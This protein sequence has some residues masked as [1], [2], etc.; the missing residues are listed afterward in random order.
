MDGFEAGGAALEGEGRCAAEPLVRGGE[1]R[2]VAVERAAGTA[3]EPGTG[4]VER[5]PE[6]CEVGHDEPSGGRRGRGADVRG[7]VEE[8]GVLLVPDGAH[9]RHRAGGDRPHEPLVGEGK[10]VLEAAPATGDHDDVGAAGGEVGDG[11]SDRRRR[12]RPLHERLGDDDVRRRKPRG[13]RGQDVPLRG[14]V[15]PGDEADQLRDPGK[16]PLPLGC[17]EPLGGQ[18]LL[19][20][21]EGGEMRAEPVPLDRQRPEV[22]V[23]ALLVQL[24]TTVDVN[25]LA[26]LEAEPQ[27]VEEPALHLHREART[28]LRVLQREVDGRPLLLAAQLGDLALDPQG[29]QP[30]EPRGDPLVERADREDLAAVDERA[31]DLHDGPMLVRYRRISAAVSCEQPARTSSTAWCR[32]ASEVA[33]FFASSCG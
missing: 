8:R 2:G 32:S 28:V 20:L 25:S 5:G 6:L 23:A 15:V 30:L 9:D 16:R 27:A 7:E 26:V 11:R 3:L 33:I 31:L 12:L 14:G 10:Q 29:R 17:E 18:L 1:P 24:R 19:E 22:E 4:A 13:D 21:L